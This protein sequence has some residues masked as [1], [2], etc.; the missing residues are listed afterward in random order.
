MCVVSM[1]GDSF[2][3]RWKD[4]LPNDWTIP[5]MPMPSQ[6][7]APPFKERRI[8]VSHPFQAISRVEFDLLKKE[9]EIMKDLLERAIKY[10]KDN[11]E[12]HCETESK[13]AFL[14]QVAKAVGVDLEEVFGK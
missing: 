6:P 3:D 12:P 5:A 2:Q 4:R 1:I 11:N 13:I 7:M 9:V 14:K 10:D 8:D